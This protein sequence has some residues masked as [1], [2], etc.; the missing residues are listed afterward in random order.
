MSSS[1]KTINALK[2]TTQQLAKVVGKSNLDSSRRSQRR[3]RRKRRG[4]K[5]GFLANPANIHL[6]QYVDTLNDP[7]SCGPMKLGFGTMV[8]TETATLY[9]RGNFTANVDGSFAAF[10]IPG[11]GGSYSGVFSNA[12][13]ANVSTWVQT[14]WT[15]QSTV[16]PLF[17]QFR[18]VSF[19]L[20]IYL[21]AGTN[22]A[23]GVWY[24]GCCPSGSQAQLAATTPTNLASNVWLVPGV[25][26]EGARA[27]SR[28]QDNSAYEFLAGIFGAGS[29]VVYPHSLPVISVIGLAP[30]ANLFVEAVMHIE[31]LSGVTTTVNVFGES[32]QRPEPGLSDYFS[33]VEAMWRAAYPYL[34][35]SGILNYAQSAF[36][37]GVSDRI[38]QTIAPRGRAGNNLV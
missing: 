18:V 20:R 15:N 16:Q 8:P 5:T 30:S 17:D 4:N 12:S 29:G 24:V 31:G 11:I 3:R 9:M 32:D 35:S 19:G 14:P 21:N 37:Q 2:Q 25:T 34:R 7:F 36:E 38:I 22:N 13:G 26:R 10:A 6:R 27:V 33:S 28:P 23:P 1:K